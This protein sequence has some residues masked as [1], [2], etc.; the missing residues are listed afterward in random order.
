[1]FSSIVILITLLLSSEKV[2]VADFVLAES[3]R[4]EE[5]YA[6]AEPL[7]ESSL[8]LYEKVHGPDH[9]YDAIVLNGLGELYQA[10]HSP[11]GRAARLQSAFFETSPPRLGFDYEDHNFD[12]NLTI[13]N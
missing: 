7:Y 1:M 5:K 2:A 13:T 12:L 6:E 10:E 8:A 3:L 11:K 9:P 4:N